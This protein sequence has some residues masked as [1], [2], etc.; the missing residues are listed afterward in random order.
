MFIAMF[1]FLSHVWIPEDYIYIYC[2]YI[3]TLLSF[4]MFFLL[5]KSDQDTRQTFFSACPILLAKGLSHVEKLQSMRW[6]SV[7]SGNLTKLLKMTIDIVD[8]PMNSMV[9]FHMLNYQRV[10]ALRGVS[11]WLAGRS[12]HG[13]SV[14]CCIPETWRRCSFLFHFDGW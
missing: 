10:N 11:E 12:P 2:I 1:E 8:F 3:Y 7:P 6:F 9:I 4:L 5:A 13:F 14:T